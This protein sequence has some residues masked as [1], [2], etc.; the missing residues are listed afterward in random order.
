MLLQFIRN[1]RLVGRDHIPP[2]SQHVNLNQV[3]SDALV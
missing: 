1:L 2:S 3:V